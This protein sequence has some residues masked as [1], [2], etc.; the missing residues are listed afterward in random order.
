VK[1]NICPS[2][3]R[4]ITAV[5]VLL[6]SISCDFRR[7]DRLARIRGGTMWVGAVEHRPWTTL[8]SGGGAG[9]IEGALVAEVARDLQARIEWV[10]GPESQLLRALELGEL[11]LVIG[12]LSDANPWRR[13]VAFTKPIYTDTIVIGGVPQA[14]P[15]RKLGGQTVAVLP[16]DPAA[17]YVRRKGGVPRT[18]ANLGMAPGLLAAPTWLL[19]SFGF[20][21]TGI[22]LYEARHVIAVAPGDDAWLEAVEESLAKRTP[23]IGEVL[24]TARP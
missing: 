11:D 14:V 24:R 5:L 13:R 6:V 12:G 19:P 7:V 3:L 1:P 2:S 17:A 22:T 10:R 9:G 8:P 21:P 23:M 4:P 18:V 16:G 20:Q 15:L